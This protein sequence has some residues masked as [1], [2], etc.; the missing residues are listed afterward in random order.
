M[1]EDNDNPETLLYFAYGP[2]MSVERVEPHVPTARMIGPALARNKRLAFNKRG[3]DGTGK[4]NLTDDPNS[5][6]WGVLYEIDM[7]DLKRLDQSEGGYEPIEIQVMTDHEGGLRATAYVAAN[8]CE[9]LLPLEAYKAVIV[10]AA[11]QA[12]LPEDYIEGLEKIES[13]AGPNQD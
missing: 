6:V 1:Y 13:Q 3:V 10:D 4:A 9:E 2:N 11:Y 5:V 12:Q 7:D 8:A